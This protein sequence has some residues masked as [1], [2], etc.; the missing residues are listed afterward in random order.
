T[1][2]DEVCFCSLLG[3][4]HAGRMA[5]ETIER[6]GIDGSR[7]L[8]TLPETPHSVILFDPTG[9]RQIHV[10]LKAIQET[11]YSVEIAENALDGCS[12]A[13]LCNINFSRPL[14]EVARK[15][16]IVIATDLHALSSIHDSYNQDFLGQADIVFVSHEHLGDAPEMFAR[17]LFDAWHQLQIVVV[18]MG[19]EGALLAVRENGVVKRFPAVTVRPIVNTIGAGDALFSGFT[20]FYAQQRDPE[21]ALH[22]AT[23]F[24]AWKIGASGGAEGFLTEEELLRL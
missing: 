11:P 9:R 14:L 17:H 12:L 24:A 4:D 10:D 5:L 15:R 7:L 13:V 3:R 2:G 23:R 21:R 22:L 18:G 20:H 6:L 19:A 8:A 1:L 16:G